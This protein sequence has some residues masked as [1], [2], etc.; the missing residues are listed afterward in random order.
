MK[1]VFILLFSFFWLQNI[2]AQTL[3]PT[4]IAS[5]GDY[6]KTSSGSLS[7]TLGET[8]VSYFG[9]GSNSLSE[10]FQ[11][12]YSTITSIVDA[13]VAELQITAFPNPAKSFLTLRIENSTFGMYTIYI[14]DMLGKV[15]MTEKLSGNG[16]LSK[17]LNIE[18][19][20]QGTYFLHVSTENNSQ[21]TLKIVHIN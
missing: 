6:F 21:H 3:S 9:T 19:I 18:N 13:N 2:K 15:L 4:V 7:W 8:A 11:Q 16:I 17:E 20:P 5:A 1:T 10:G 14:M 12:S